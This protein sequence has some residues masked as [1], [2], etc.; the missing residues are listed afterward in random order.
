[1]PEWRKGD[2]HY[3]H[4]N[5][6]MLEG[7]AAI[8]DF[9]NVGFN[10]AKK[11]IR[12]NNLPAVRSYNGRWLTSKR[13]VMAWVLEGLEHTSMEL[14]PVLSALLEITQK[15]AEMMTSYA[16]SSLPNE[17]EMDTNTS[18]RKPEQCGRN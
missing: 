9:L 13:A 16:S 10:T 17:T 5:P 6:E 7:T 15:R 12:N 1:V 2:P 3:I 11:W 8:A 4:P 18:E 14:D